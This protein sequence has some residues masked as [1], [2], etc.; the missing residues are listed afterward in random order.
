MRKILIIGSGVAGLTTAKHLLDNGHQVTIW[1]KESPDDNPVTS[2]NAYALWVPYK[3]DTDP[4]IEGWTDYS[5]QVYQDLAQLAGSG[6]ILRDN[7]NLQT[8]V[9][10]PWYAGKYPFF[11][12]AGEDEISSQYAD[13]W[14]LEKAPIIDPQQYLLWLK[15]N[16]A[17]QGANFVKK[18]VE[19]LDDIPAEFDAVINCTGGG[20]RELVGDTEITPLYLQVI[21]VAANGFDKVVVDDVGPN[22]MVCIVPHEDYIKVGAVITEGSEKPFVNDLDTVDIL[23]RASKV[24]PDFK[25]DG[26]D[27]LDVVAASRPS[28]P[29]PRV[30]KTTLADGRCLVHNYGHGSTGYITAHGVAAEICGYFGNTGG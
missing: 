26:M 30:E 14:V 6:V 17:I 16:L 29:R 22:A 23:A 3:D 24:H 5:L 1:S 13:A 15:V 4:R 2:D 7:F 11:R 27:V 9:H 18:T 21:K 25:V 20:A 19:S 28:R 12:H 8:K 10:E